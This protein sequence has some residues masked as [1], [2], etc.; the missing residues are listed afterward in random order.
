MQVL[1]GMGHPVIG[2]TIMGCHALR[3]IFLPK[4]FIQAGKS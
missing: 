3:G 2:K 4:H 1:K